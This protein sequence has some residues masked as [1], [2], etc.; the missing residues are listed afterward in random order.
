M[1]AAVSVTEA[2]AFLRLVGDE[3]DGLILILIAAAQARIEAAVGL[4]LDS[5]SPA[6]LRL[7]I[8]MLVLVAY[9]RGEAA[10]TDAGT[11]ADVESWLAPYRPVRL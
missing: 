3:E 11:Q 10:M 1:T 2:K 5:D 7:A 6:A 8:L 9:E 4:G